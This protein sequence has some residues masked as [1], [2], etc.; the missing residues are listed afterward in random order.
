M[1]NENYEFIQRIPSHYVGEDCVQVMNPHGLNSGITVLNGN[2]I[3]YHYKPNS[4]FFI[5][6]YVN[7]NRKEQF[8]YS[9]IS[10]HKRRIGLKKYEFVNQ[11]LDFNKVYIQISN[12]IIK[13]NYSI[14]HGNEALVATKYIIPTQE[15]D[16]FMSRNEILELFKNA[17]GGSF[18]LDGGH[19]A[20]IPLTSE[21]DILEYY[22]NQILEAKKD[23][24]DGEY[25]DTY[26]YRD[27]NNFFEKSINKLTIAD[28][29]NIRILDNSILICTQ[30]NEITSV[31][32]IEII[33]MGPDNYKV[34]SYNYPI[35]YYT[36]EHMLKLEQT[37]SKEIRE[38][39]IPKHLN[40]S[41]SKD[42]IEEQ[43]QL[44]LERKNK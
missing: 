25:K 43:K 19:W 22:K 39:K 3:T 2:E 37:N 18:T 28:V 12:G 13:E 32:V 33:F 31:K 21:E 41:I 44:V 10:S 1:K 8:P 24:V 5:N 6:K 7:D 26:S 15:E 40:K 36:L 17:N 4:H 23:I 29:P 11:L 20:K 38:P 14:K 34:K 30:N 27:F 42:E 9:K 35:T 16:K